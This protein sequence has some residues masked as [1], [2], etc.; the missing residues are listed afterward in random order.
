MSSSLINATASPT[1][2]TN[3]WRKGQRITKSSQATLVRRR[4]GFT[5]V[6]LTLLQGFG[7]LVL[8]QYNPAHSGS[9]PY[10][11]L[12]SVCL[13]GRVSN[14]IYH[15]EVASADSTRYTKGIML[16]SC[17]RPPSSTRSLSPC[18]HQHGSHIWC[19]G[20]GILQYS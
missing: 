6:G 19:I 2:T 16:V 7:S 20:V 13:F 12:S 18:R 11:T 5:R 14:T 3:A 1:L 17:L 8:N 10:S 4:K 9:A 15:T